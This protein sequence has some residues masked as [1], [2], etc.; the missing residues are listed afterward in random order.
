[1]LDSKGFDLWSESY[2]QSIADSKGYPFEGYYDV[3][4]YVYNQLGSNISGSKILDI[5]FGT[6]TL[7]NRLYQ[8]GAIIYGVD[9]SANMIK[10]AQEKMPNGRFVQADFSQGIPPE[11][12]GAKFNPIISAYAIHHLD[13]RAK[14]DFIKEL[15]T[16]LAPG[17]QII[18]ADVAF[19]TISDFEE[20]RLKNIDRWDNDE[21]Y[22]VME[23]IEDLLKK[24]GLNFAYHQISSCAGALVI[25]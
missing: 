17:G 13:H 19:R 25:K 16:L 14:V 8:E 9:F 7:T 1:M 6:G 24:Q 20:C 3:L 18:I 4:A 10:I 5:G 12:T 11:L 21:I 23:E 2:D 22:I 15:K